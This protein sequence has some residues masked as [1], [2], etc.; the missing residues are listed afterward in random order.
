[1]ID[2][3]TALIVGL[4]I[5]VIWWSTKSG[6][7]NFMYTDESADI[8]ESFINTSEGA[9][10]QWDRDTATFEGAADEVAKEYTEEL[11]NTVDKTIVQSHRDYIKDT[12]FLATLGP[13]HVTERADFTPT[14]P[15][16]GLPRAAHYQNPG[17][18]TTARIA[19][20]ENPKDIVDAMNR[21]SAYAL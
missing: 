6:Y 18:N 17:A 11:K 15:F 19:G 3:T 8:P 1:M 10:Y 7:N 16:H 14:V 4:I 9:N 2:L 12:N 13:S 21:K 5:V 20:S